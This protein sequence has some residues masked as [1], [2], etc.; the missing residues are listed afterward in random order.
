MTS[1]TVDP[2]QYAIFSAMR[3]S[4][5][6]INVESSTDGSEIKEIIGTLKVHTAWAPAGSKV[7]IQ[8]TTRKVTLYR[9]QPTDIAKK[10]RFTE[11]SG[12]RFSDIPFSKVKL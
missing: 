1:K 5:E 12:F 9:Q 7:L 3:D 2:M 8:I 4:S 6:Y 11:L 10:G